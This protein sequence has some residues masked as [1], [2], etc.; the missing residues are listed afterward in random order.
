MQKIFTAS[1]P[2][3]ALFPGYFSYGLGT[4]LEHLWWFTSHPHIV[5][6]SATGV[7]VH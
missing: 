5:G 6:C 4:R 1:T 2:P 7:H 3:I